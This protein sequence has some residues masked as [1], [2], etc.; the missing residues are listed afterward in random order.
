M[1]KKG[2]DAS[3][4]ATPSCT[5]GELGDEVMVPS[6]Y[7]VENPNRKHRLSLWR[8]IC[9]FLVYFHWRASKPCGD[10]RVPRSYIGT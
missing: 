6:M 2:Y 5:H 10:G 4:T 7:T 1:L 9:Q 3:K 8:D